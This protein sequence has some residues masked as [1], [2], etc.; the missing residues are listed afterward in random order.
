MN[1][2]TA[3]RY[4]KA[5]FD[6]A[7][8]EKQ[9]GPIRERLE[10]TDRMIRAQAELLDLCRNPLYNLDEK[11]QVLGSLGERIGS[12]PLLRRFM[13]LLIQKNR[14]R[15]LPEIAKLFGMLVDEAQG[16]EHVRVRVAR[17]LSR[18]EE[19]GLKKKL[20][21]IMRRDLDLTVE[22]DPSLIGGI[23]VYTG[24]RVYDG[25]VKGQFQGLRRELA[26]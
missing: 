20:E 12:P 11:K 22:S 13:D 16:L 14:L 10:Q 2:A 4:A 23:V 26:K 25:S 1:T 8:Q 3:R 5:L 15:E 9:P 17:S 24:N 6:L 18:E 19:T 7:R 21:T